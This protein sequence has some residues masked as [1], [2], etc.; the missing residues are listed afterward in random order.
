MAHAA[1][2]AGGWA[3]ALEVV[4]AAGDIVVE[5]LGNGASADR[6]SIDWPN[7]RQIVWEV[8]LTLLDESEHSVD[9]AASL[10]VESAFLLVAEISVDTL[11]LGEMDGSSLRAASIFLVQALET[12][13][14]WASAPIDCV[15]NIRKAWTL[16]HLSRLLDA[17]SFAAPV[18]DSLISAMSLRSSITLPY[19]CHR[20]FRKIDPSGL[21]SMRSE[22]QGKAKL[23]SLFEACLDD[24]WT[25]NAAKFLQDVGVYAELC[26][27]GRDLLKEFISRCGCVGADSIDDA[28]FHDVVKHVF[29]LPT[30]PEQIIEFLSTLDL[31]NFRPS[32]VGSISEAVSIRMSTILSTG[33]EVYFRYLESFCLSLAQVHG[34]A[35][36]LASPIFIA[37]VLLF[38]HTEALNPSTFKSLLRVLCSTWSEGAV[39]QLRVNSSEIYGAV[40]RL[41]Q[42]FDVGADREGRLHSLVLLVLLL[43]KIDELFPGADC[44]EVLFLSV[45]ELSCL[46]I[47]DPSSAM[48]VSRFLQRRIDDYQIDAARDSPRFFNIR[49]LNSRQRDQFSRATAFVYCDLYGIPFFR[50]RNDSPLIQDVPTGQLPALLRF[51]KFL[52]QDTDCSVSELRESYRALFRLSPVADPPLQPAGAMIDAYLFEDASDSKSLAEYLSTYAPD[53]LEDH[54]LLDFYSN[55]YHEYSSVYPIAVSG[56]MNYKDCADTVQSMESISLPLIRLLVLDLLFN[57]LKVTSWTSLHD[58]LRD[59]Q[60]QAADKVAEY[61]LSDSFHFDRSPKRLR[62]TLALLT[63]DS[64]A[65]DADSFKDAVLSSGC[66]YV[67]KET[68]FLVKLLQIRE[69]C[70][71]LCVRLHSVFLL[72]FERLRFL[73]RLAKDDVCTWFGLLESHAFLMYTVAATRPKGSRQRTMYLHEAASWYTFYA[74]L[75]VYRALIAN[76]N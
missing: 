50:Y 8:W 13:C 28:V 34:Q 37:G 56:H 76:H 65:S 27:E 1:A 40:H 59:V 7:I 61:S 68:P 62:A 4:A 48:K 45:Q 31:G 38:A 42:F 72:L 75:I 15:S 52:S 12:V 18:V 58:C 41:L 39:E 43:V 26:H 5:S 71:A 22:A 64:D 25:L 21:D 46:W 70:T 44:A 66:P 10:M 23:K 67:R 55:F 17:I 54:S 74:H 3:K 29:S 2:G 35:E 57:P 32:F 9:G 63:A 14:S 19:V 24:F 73:G 69:Y 53:P 16:L 51:V 33:D 60:E 36:S 20:S 49:K 6:S 11:L 47:E 30:F